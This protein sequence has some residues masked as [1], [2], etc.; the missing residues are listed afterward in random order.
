MADL[1]NALTRYFLET[2][3][4]LSVLA[5]RMGRSPSTLTRPV[6]GERNPSIGLA[7]EV[8]RAT[9]GKVPA[10]AFIEI[11]MSAQPAVAKDAAA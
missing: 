5:A 6:N 1:E 10:N 2:G 3:E 4:N 11:C 9:G 7:R 8:E